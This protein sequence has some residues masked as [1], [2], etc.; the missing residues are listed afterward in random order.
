MD[1]HSCQRQQADI[2]QINRCK[3]RVAER[4]DTFTYLSKALELAGNP[5]RLKILYLLYKEKQLCVC[6][7]SDILDMGISAV[8]QHLR[9][10][11][12]REIINMTR[13][14]QTLFYSV[15]RE[16]NNLLKPFFR[17]LDDQPSLALI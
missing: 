14:A 15:N 16:Y 3:V 11:K 8:S 9:K 2:T 4:S 1:H 13:Q 17:I 5:T 7:L 12:D 6:D 10:L